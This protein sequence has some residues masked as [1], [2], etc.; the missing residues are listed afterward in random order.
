[1]AGEE[2]P[3]GEAR[4]SE[5]IEYTILVGSA[6]EVSS[7]VRQHLHVGWSL[8]EGPSVGRSDSGTIIVQAMVKYGVGRL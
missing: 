1:M 3:R 4:V 8:Y 7:L 2:S 5:V 6:A